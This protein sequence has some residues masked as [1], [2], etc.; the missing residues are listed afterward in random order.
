MRLRE[1]VALVV[2]VSLLIPFALSATSDVN[3]LALV[4]KLAA[5]RNGYEKA[6]RDLVAYYNSAGYSEKF[7]RASEELEAFRQIPTR[8]YLQLVSPIRPPA[9]KVR[10][11]K[12]ADILYEDG[13][14]YKNYPDLLGKK[15]RLIKAIERFM[16]LLDSYPDSDKADEACYMV[17]EIYEGFYFQDP[18]SAV[19]HYDKAAKINPHIGMPAFYRAG[20]IYANKIPRP[21][22]AAERF[23]KVI[24]YSLNER[25]R[26]AAATK[27]ERMKEANLIK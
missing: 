26:Q 19:T 16:M 22:L 21:A 8:D 27:L 1:S 12:Q 6:L 7:F 23:R 5:A 3:E 20:L 18:F 9:V 4:D 17:G 11:I 25:H 13:L 10:S 15:T 2:A 24:Q 14:T